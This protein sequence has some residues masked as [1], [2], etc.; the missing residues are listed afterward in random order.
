MS[1]KPNNKYVM[2]KFFAIVIVSIMLFSLA[3]FAFAQNKE[4][5]QDRKLEIEYPEVAG[6]KPE[7]VTILVSE[8]VKYIFNLLIWISGIVALMSLI[9]G[10]IFYLTSAGEPEK[11]SKAKKQI[12]AAFFG[13]VILLSSYLILTTINPDL[14]SLEMSTLEEIVFHPLDTP[15]SETK[16]PK[17]LG[18]IEEIAEKIKEIIIPGIE[19]SSRKIKDLTDN[20]DC[21]GTQSLCACTGGDESDSCQPQGCYAGPGFQ[22]CPNQSE[23]KENQKRIIAWKD[24]ILYYRNRALAEEKDLFD[25]TSK[26]LAEEIRYY[27]DNIA[28]ETDEKIIEYFNEQI[29]ELQK[30]KELKE[31]L[32]AKLKELADKIKQI[33]PFMSEIGALP[34]KCLYDEGVYGVNNKCQASCKGKC[35]DYKDGCEPGECSGGNPCPVG[36]IN[37]QLLLIQGLQ[38]KII[39]KS[40]EILNIIDEIIKHKTITI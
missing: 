39:D 17:L 32:T 20:C 33:E 3:N 34:D 35:H 18:G 40:D 21:A 19:L 7:Q 28:I 22:P 36:E 2:K 38:P 9:I 26:V 10:G 25:E 8:Y 12:L 4:P 15:A 16:V 24:E 6:E 5:E 27:Q 31:D 29:A 1:A 37:D 13:I 30:E 11:L 23:I 14:V